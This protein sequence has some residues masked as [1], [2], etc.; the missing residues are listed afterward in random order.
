MDLLRIE[1]SRGALLA[2]RELPELHVIGS[3]AID[4]GDGSWLVSAYAPDEAAIERLLE[5]GLV[6]H[7]LK[8]AEQVRTEWAAASAAP[9]GYLSSGALS[10]RLKRL[11]SDHPEGC[12]IEVLP[13]ATH[14]GR[15]VTMLRLGA[16]STA[17][18]VVLGGVHAREW[19]PPD[20]LLS[21]AE[22]LVGAYARNGSMD[23]A[24]WIDD[25]A[26]PPITYGAW[27]VSAGDVKRI[28]EGVTL[29]LVPL[30]AS[31]KSRPSGLMSKFRLR[32]TPAHHG[33]V[34]PA[35]GGRRFLRH[36]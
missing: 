1:G 34:L 13:H 14:E 17:T 35:G 29:V 33:P 27:S 36:M 24:Q 2:L 8:G 22:G 15:D 18:I 30:V 6:V 26:R 23:H 20:A 32:S 3:S 9:V 28:V 11:A 7:R 19:A 16:G 10:E 25:T 21:L 31:V 4:R 5:R 12:S